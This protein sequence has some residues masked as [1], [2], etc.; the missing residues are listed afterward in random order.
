MPTVNLAK[1]RPKFYKDSKLMQALDSVIETELE[2]L[3]EACASMVKEVNISTADE[4]LFVWERS[5]ALVSGGGLT[6]AQRRSRVLARLRQ[7]DATTAERIKIIAESFVNGEAEVTEIFSDYT[8]LIEFV[9]VL[10]VPDNMEG[11][12]EQ[13]NRLMPAHIA[14]TYRYK[15]RTWGELL[16]SGKTWGE[17]LSAGYTWRDL[18]EREVL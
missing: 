8:V 4:W 16:D 3:N 13:L 14:S 2:R 5:V 12:T 7:L 9:G 17:L 10:G 11:L 6:A 1:Y 18:M 15:W